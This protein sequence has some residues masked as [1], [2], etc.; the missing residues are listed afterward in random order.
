MSDYPQI[1]VIAC[2][3]DSS[4]SNRHRDGEACFICRG[5]L[6]DE[7]DFVHIFQSYSGEHK[8]R[9]G[10]ICEDCQELSA[11]QLSGKLYGDFSILES[12]YDTTDKEHRALV[13]HAES[14]K[15]TLAY[16]EKEIVN[17][18]TKLRLVGQ[19][20][21]EIR[22]AA[23]DCADWTYKTR[24]HVEMEKRSKE[25]KQITGSKPNG[26][27][28]K[29]G[30]VYLISS[31]DGHFKIGRTKD[32]PNR[33]NTLGV[34]LPFP[35][36]VIHSIPVTDMVWAERHLHERFQEKRANGE[37]F[38]LEEAD[39]EWIKCLTTLEPEGD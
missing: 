31:P 15:L 36:E 27:G 35:I 32:V 6:S 21:R 14:L 34:Q 29:K 23:E 11:E 3:N 8:V 30:Y 16:I 13:V 26:N 18:I 39:V 1:N 37:W 2:E 20:L 12:S 9:L 7:I 38:K 4:C 24:A 5:Y 33:S 17:R 19:R 25:Q 28:F 22:P 10:D